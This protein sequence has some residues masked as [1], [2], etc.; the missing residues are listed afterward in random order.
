M[1]VKWLLRKES[2]LVNELAKIVHRAEYGTPQGDSMGT[3]AVF[4]PPLL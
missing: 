3:N 2:D 1:N 4:I